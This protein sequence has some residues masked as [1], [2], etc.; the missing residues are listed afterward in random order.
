MGMEFE[1]LRPQNATDNAK[2]IAE[3]EALRKKQAQQIAD[4]QEMTAELAER[5]GAK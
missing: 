3:L 1:S 2:L 5:G 4:L